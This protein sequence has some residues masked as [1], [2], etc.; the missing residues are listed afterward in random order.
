MDG[1]QIRA[2]QTGL[3]LHLRGVGKLVECVYRLGRY[4]HFVTEQ[5]QWKT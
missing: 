3:P 2:S 5:F 4:S 1:G